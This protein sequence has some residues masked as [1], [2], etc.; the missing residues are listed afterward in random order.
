MVS[1]SLLVVRRKYGRRSRRYTYAW[2][3]EGLNLYCR[4][5]VRVSLHKD[6]DR[7]ETEL[8]NKADEFFVIRVITFLVEQVVYC[9]GLLYLVLLSLQVYCIRY[10]QFL[11]YRSQ[12]FRDEQTSLLVQHRV[13]LLFTLSVHFKVYIF[14]NI[15]FDLK[16][17]SYNT[18]CY[19]G[20]TCFCFG[21]YISVRRGIVI[22][23]VLQFRG[24]WEFHLHPTLRSSSDFITN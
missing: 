6:E 11:L 23:K 2:M 24:V 7:D 9:M 18:G 8:C 20:T 22:G 12:K 19:F 17:L 14:D 16:C 10:F 3:C 4:Y 13:S 21:Q 15:Y 1:F 5:S